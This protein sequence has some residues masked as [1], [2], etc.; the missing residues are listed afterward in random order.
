MKKK[1]KKMS[2]VE[3]CEV[4]VVDEAYLE[5]AKKG[6]ALLKIPSHTISSWGA[7]RHS[8][9]AEEMTDY[10]A[11]SSKSSGSLL[12]SHWL[13]WSSVVC[14]FWSHETDSEGKF[15]CRPRLR[16]V[17]LLI[18]LPTPIASQIS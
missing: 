7:S 2:E 15:S 4:P 13:S 1:S 12:F 17:L 3:E 8:L 6:G 9:T 11:G 5:D 18:L 16:S 14:R 10:G